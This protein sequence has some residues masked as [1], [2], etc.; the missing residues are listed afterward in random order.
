M[1]QHLY[2]SLLIGMGALALFQ[3]V[4]VKAEISGNRYGN[5]V[6]YKSEI[7]SA[8]AW[9][10][11]KNNKSTNGK[12]KPLILDVRRVEEYVKGHPPGALSIPFPHVHKSPT[13]ADDNS[14]G[15]IG[16]DI[17]EDPID[18]GFQT[19][20]NFNDG[21]IP[22]QEFTDYVES[23]VPD[24]KTP[25]YLVCATGFR[26]VQAGNALAKAGY[27]EVRN[28]WEG[29]NGLPKFTQTRAGLPEFKINE[30]TGAIEFTK[31]DLNHDGKIDV[32]DNDGWAFYQGLPVETAFKKKLVDQRFLDLYQDELDKL[33]P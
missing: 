29:W 9:E 30:Q 12:L 13:K 33:T 16:Y 10:L 21:V 26:S 22:I 28:V 19:A 25:L 11:T 14:S 27:S 15:Y 5:P 7:S 1:K 4:T 32:N 8:E 2:N 3:S 17:S 23:V 24:K 20:P 6:L 31:L 18:V